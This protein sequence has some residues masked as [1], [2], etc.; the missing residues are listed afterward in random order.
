MFTTGALRIG[1]I[2]GIPIRIHFTFLLVLP[3]IALGFTRVFTEAVRIAEVPVE[4]LGGPAWIWGL[5][6]AIA[7]FL[8][9]LV[10]E[11][12]HSLYALRKGGR[13]RDIT[14]IMI[15][16]VSQ[17]SELPK[18]GRHEAIMA[19]VGPLTS[20]A[21]GAAFYLGFRLTDPTAWFNLRFALFHLAILN[22]FLGLF[23]LLPAFPMD[24]GRILRGLL[25]GRMG[26]VRATQT[27]A[28]VGKVFAVLFAVLGFL[29]LNIL[30]ILVAFFVYLGASAEAKQ[31]LVRAILGQ[32]RV[33]DLMLTAVDPVALESSAF[34][35]GEK[36]VRNR[37][38]ALAVH[39][40]SA[41]AGVVTLDQVRA[42]D[43][44]RR[45]E[46]PVSS[47]FERVPALSPDDDLAKAARVLG[48]NRS[49]ALPVV[50]EGRLVGVLSQAEMIRGLKLR[51]LQ[52][53]QHPY[54]L[55][56]WRRRA[57]A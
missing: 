14:L 32:V 34:E 11:L 45:A 25:A 24:G 12:A 48:E 18:R 23:N 50:L 33:A 40:G 38:L 56:G 15:G 35:V 29:S 19:F 13:V 43:P 54:E 17:I 8:A 2:R 5:V 49:H 21:I 42:V 28:T 22:V 31:V 27:A 3:F 53:S 6:V 51:E 36:M 30:L 26:M 9:V 10:H 44:G 1:T 16:G 52:L 7:L 20:L 55:P 57:E 4:R 47:I 37:R 39:D 41:I 46:V